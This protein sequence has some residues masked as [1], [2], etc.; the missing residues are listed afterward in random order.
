MSKK[1]IESHFVI[2]KRGHVQQHKNDLIKA[3]SAVNFKSFKNQPQS[4]MK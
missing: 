3:K 1:P 2:V 4:H